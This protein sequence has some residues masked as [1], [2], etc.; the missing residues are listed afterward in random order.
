MG[1]ISK[2]AIGLHSLEIAT[3]CINNYKI[4]DFVAQY[5][6]V[7]CYNPV[8]CYIVTYR[9]LK[10]KGLKDGRKDSRRI[11]VIQKKKQKKILIN[12]VG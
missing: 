4:L 10:G 7:R 1:C 5:V 9:I 11:F 12:L 2:L 6:L 3:I 8:K